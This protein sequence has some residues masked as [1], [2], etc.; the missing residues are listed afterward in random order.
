MTL[1]TLGASEELGGYAD[2]V[3]EKKGSMMDGVSTF[4]DT[5]GEAIVVFKDTS[6]KKILRMQIL[7]MQQVGNHK[8]KELELLIK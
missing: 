4:R 1:L 8:E 2:L 5:L 7:R 6:K 3:L